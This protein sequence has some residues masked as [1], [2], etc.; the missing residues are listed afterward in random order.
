MGFH[1]GQSVDK[2]GG[3]GDVI[4]FIV[5]SISSYYIHYKELMWELCTDDDDKWHWAHRKSIEQTTNEELARIKNGVL[6]LKNMKTWIDD[7]RRF[8]RCGGIEVLLHAM[9]LNRLDAG[10]QF[11]A[12]ILISY[13]LLSVGSDRVDSHNIRKDVAKVVVGNGGAQQVLAAMGLHIHDERV[14]YLGLSCIG[15]LRSL[16]ETGSLILLEETDFVITDG[17]IA[18]VVEAM[19]AHVGILHIVET[20]LDI[21]RDWC[22]AGCDAV[23]LMW[24]HGAVV[25]VIRAMGIPYREVKYDNFQRTGCKILGSLASCGKD[26]RIAEDVAL[27]GVCVRW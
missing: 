4:E 15:S 12:L 13:M 23:L 25:S 11:N 24:K 26:P 21:L 9:R 5:H 6:T 8:L 2:F 1:Y 17:G 20:C 10:T 18:A 19:N 3:I 16:K 14:Q 7:P 27:K 22:S